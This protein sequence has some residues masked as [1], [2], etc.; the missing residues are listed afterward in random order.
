MVTDS[1]SSIL[2]SYGL[3]YEFNPTKLKD[4]KQTWFSS[5]V[6]KLSFSIPLTLIN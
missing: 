4:G 5:A 6:A 2:H 3:I 1:L